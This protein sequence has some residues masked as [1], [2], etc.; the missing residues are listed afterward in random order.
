M[1]HVV[2]VVV[3]S[4]SPNTVLLAFQVIAERN[5]RV[6]GSVGAPYEQTNVLVAASDPDGLIADLRLRLGPRVPVYEEPWAHEFGEG[7]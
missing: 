6:L 4:C 2:K 3:G 7:A 5:E 1:K